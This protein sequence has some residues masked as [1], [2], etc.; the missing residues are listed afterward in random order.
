MSNKLL[1][2]FLSSSFSLKSK[3]CCV[4]KLIWYFG[5]KM[6]VFTNIVCSYELIW[7]LSQ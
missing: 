7:N 2:T 5:A 4:F 1:K 6:D 3:L